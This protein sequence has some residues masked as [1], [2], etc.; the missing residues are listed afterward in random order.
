M[1]ILITGGSGYIAS[2]LSKFLRFH[3]LDVVTLS[4]KSLPDEFNIQ[5]QIGQRDNL[6]DIL[7]KCKPDIV[8]H[9][10]WV[11]SLFLCESQPDY[12]HRVNVENSIDLIDAI[13]SVTPSSKIMFISS[14][15]VFDGIRGN[16]SEVD[17]PSPRTVYGI[18]KV[19]VENAIKGSGLSHLIIRTA[20][21]FTRGGKFFDFLFEHLMAGKQVDAYADAYFTPTYMN[22]LLD[23]LLRMIEKNAEGTFHLAGPQRVSRYQFGIE[24]ARV[25]NC[26]D[27]L[28]IPTMRPSGGPIAYDVSLDSNKVRKFLNNYCPLFSEAVSYALGRLLYPYFSFLDDRGGI[29]GIIQDGDWK[30]INYVESATGA[31]RGK[32]YHNVAREGFFIIDGKVLVT[33]H[34]LDNGLKESFVVS[35]G[36][37][38]CIEPRTVHTFKVLQGARWINFLSESMKGA[39]TDILRL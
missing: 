19:E 30:E 36:D 39:N 7:I 35:R 2:R 4:Q 6:L 8:I 5:C 15:Y 20:N 33:L 18:H 21:V 3:S 23:S 9:T 37:T 14:D 25:L 13:R 34:Y 16:Y 11:N 24:M 22:Y 27:R 10:A 29:M 38:F 12:C 31:T 1:R 28:V 26:D 32:H 17:V